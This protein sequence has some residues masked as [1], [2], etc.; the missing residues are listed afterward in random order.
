MESAQGL[1]DG[2][3]RGE[4]SDCEVAANKSA[5]S[6][7]DKQLEL[8]RSCTCRRVADRASCA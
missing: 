3:M 5:R 1:G 4:W 8:L 2:S 7:S 6:R